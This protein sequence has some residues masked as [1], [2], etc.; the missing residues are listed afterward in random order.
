M[1]ISL[2]LF[3]EFSLERTVTGL[4]RTAAAP[5]ELLKK[6]RLD[7]PFDFSFF[8]DLLIF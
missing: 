3:L 4:L 6:V 5:A 1:G 8:D 2:L 7:M